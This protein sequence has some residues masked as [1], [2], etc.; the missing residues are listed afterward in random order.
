MSD[1]ITRGFTVQEPSALAAASSS[2]T[3]VAVLDWCRSTAD[4]IRSSMDRS[5]LRLT[6]RA[7][8]YFGEHLTMDF[9]DALHEEVGIDLHVSGIYRLHDHGGSVPDLVEG[10]H[11][12]GLIANLLEVDAAIGDP[13]PHVGFKTE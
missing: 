5:S 9:V 2:V 4:R 10:L 11:L 6:L 13:F 1:E 7:Y 8:R 3:D 12:A